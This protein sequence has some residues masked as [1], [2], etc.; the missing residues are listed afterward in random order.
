MTDEVERYLK[1]SEGWRDE[2]ARLRAILLSLGLDEALKWGK[3]CYSAE[4][5]NI[6]II[7]KFK[8]FVALMFFKGAL[9][10]DPDQVL[11]SQGENS[12]SALRIPFRSAQDVERLEPAIRRL[13]EGA[14]EVERQGLK[15]EGKAETAIP[16]ELA[17]RLDAEPDLA[18]AFRN[19][20]PGRQREYCLHVG[21]AKQSGTR[22]RRI[23]A[24]RERILA[25]KGL[26]D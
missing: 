19:L 2:T 5:G 11:E 25:G 22:E 10:D 17:A 24:A 1:R 20:T 26:R 13:V 6:A 14:V 15:V 9:L 21:A 3:P 8:D 18:D 12:R 4:G 23:E 16:D 7:Q